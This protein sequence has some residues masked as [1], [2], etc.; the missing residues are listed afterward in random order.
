MRKCRTGVREWLV[1]RQILVGEARSRTLLLGE[2]MKRWLLAF[3]LLLAFDVFMLSGVF[4]H[5]WYP[6]ECCHDKDCAPY[7]SD[8]VK[9]TPNGYTLATGEFIARKA[10]R[11][12][13]D[14]HFHLCRHESTNTILCFFVPNNGS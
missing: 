6:M 2:V 7:P 12:S 5:E 8:Q 13:P 10:V 1:S 14:G 3:V 4:A 9:E 11:F